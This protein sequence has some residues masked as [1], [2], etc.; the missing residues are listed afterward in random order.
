MTHCASLPALPMMTSEI[1]SVRNLHR[2]E[3]FHRAQKLWNA[4]AQSDAN[5]HIL[6]TEIAQPLGQRI[7]RCGHQMKIAA[8]LQEVAIQHR[9]DRLAMPV[10]EKCQPMR[11][12]HLLHDDWQCVQVERA[13]GVD[14]VRNL[15]VHVRTDQPLQ[16]SRLRLQTLQVERRATS[17]RIARLSPRLLIGLIAKLLEEARRRCRRHARERR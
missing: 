17:L 16:F 15:I 6:R 9:S 4:A 14:Q 8:H 10:S 3:C 11:G 12:S 7:T 13:I 2:G 1:Y 5:N